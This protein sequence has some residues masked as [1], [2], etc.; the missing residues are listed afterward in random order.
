MS[1]VAHAM[2]SFVSYNQSYN[3][4]YVRDDSRPET[5]QDVVCGNR[6]GNTRYF[7]DMAALSANIYSDVSNLKNTHVGNW[8]RVTPDEVF[9]DRKKWTIFLGLKYDL[10]RNDHNRKMAVVFRG[11][12]DGHS[13][14][15][16]FHWFF[17]WLPFVQD[18]YEQVRVILPKLLNRL[19][20]EVK[21]YDLFSTGHSLGGGLAQFASYL[22]PQIAKVF[23]FNSSPVTGWTDFTPEHLK[24]S[25]KGNEIY[26]IHE[27]GEALEAFRLFMKMTYIFNPMPNKD[28]YFKEYRFNLRGGGIVEQHSITQLAQALA[29]AKETC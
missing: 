7:A 16:N 3:I 8:K 29:I 28:P 15:S 10:W 27:N 9:L 21:E 25:A 17:K 22:S 4:A 14:L 6:D 19:P 12:V 18:Q 11:T 24:K 26:R 1:P 2:Y 5:I 20:S 23:A 13:W